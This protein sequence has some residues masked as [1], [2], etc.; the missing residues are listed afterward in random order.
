MKKHSRPERTIALVKSHTDKQTFLLASAHLEGFS[1]DKDTGSGGEKSLKDLITVVSSNE[2]FTEL[3]KNAFK[4]TITI[5]GID[6]N[7]PPYKS[8]HVNYENEKF[9]ISSQR[10]KCLTK[11]NF[12]MSCPGDNASPTAI[13]RVIQNGVARLDYIFVHASGK[14]SIVELENIQR[15]LAPYELQSMPLNKCPI[16]TNPNDEYLAH[17]PVSDHKAVACQITFKKKKLDKIKE[18]K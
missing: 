18:K 9:K 2:F 11:A 14:I 7:T 13:N 4:N 17:L 15:D 3:D 12:I 5:L 6:L 1:I 10:T 16:I 8:K